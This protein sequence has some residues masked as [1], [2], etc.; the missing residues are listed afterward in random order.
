MGAEVITVKRELPGS[1]PETVQRALLAL[2]ECNGNTYKAMRELAQDGIKISD[3]TLL[4]WRKRKFKDEYERV[5]AEVLPRVR[6][7]AAEQ[8]MDLSA[9]LMEVEG[10]LLEKLKEKQDELPAKEVSTALRNVST[11]AA[12]HVDK[13]TILDQ[14]E[15]QAPPLDA[16]SLL[17]KLGSRGMRVE[18]VERRVVVE[19]E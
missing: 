5:R 14:D 6:R 9:R 2:A 4:D 13:A 7:K 19:G 17:R 11:S 18:A 15:G 16:E 1:N 3:V 10:E 12:I 8:H